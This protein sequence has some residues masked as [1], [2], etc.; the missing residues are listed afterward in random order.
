MSK[1]H[2]KECGL[3]NVWLSN[4]FE[5]HDTPYGE[6]VSIHDVDGLEKAIGIALVDSVHPL[7]AKEF[8][9]LRVQLDMSQKAL[10][11]LLGCEE[12]TVSLYERGQSPIPALADRSLR[13]MFLEYH[14]VDSEF[15]ELLE[16]F[17]QLD[18]ELSDLESQISFME[19]ERGWEPEMVAA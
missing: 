17:V 3:D 1:Y 9:F 12:Q 8:R 14:K 6:G 10:S 2:Y 15:R 7:K 13:Q 16:K 18:N 19:T 5:I 4:G 11:R